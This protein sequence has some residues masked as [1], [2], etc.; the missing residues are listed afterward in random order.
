MIWILYHFC[1]Q[2]ATETAH[3]ILELPAEQAAAL[4][5][6]PTPLAD[7]YREW[8]KVIPP[9]HLN[10]VCDIMRKNVAIGCEHM[11]YSLAEPVLHRGFPWFAPVGNVFDEAA[12]VEAQALCQGNVLVI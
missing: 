5:A 9:F 1:P 8:G 6:S 10:V 11:A 3:R 12:R 4:L 7:V 2:N